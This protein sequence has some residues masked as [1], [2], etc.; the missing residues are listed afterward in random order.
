MHIMFSFSYKLFFLLKH[1]DIT[2]CTNSEMT[3]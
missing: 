3:I 2:Y 1:D